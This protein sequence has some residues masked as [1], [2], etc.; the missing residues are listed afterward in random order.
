[1]RIEREVLPVRQG[2]DVDRGQGGTGERGER[3]V[4]RRVVDDARERGEVE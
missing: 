4:G 1:M 2:G 3:E